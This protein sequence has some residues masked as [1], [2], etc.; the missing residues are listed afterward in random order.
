MVSVIL[1]NIDSSNGLLPD[2]T[3]LLPWADIDLL[4]TPFCGITSR[5]FFDTHWINPHF[6]IEIYTAICPR[7]NNE[8]RYV[9][10][11]YAISQPLRPTNLASGAQEP[12][13]ASD[14]VW[15][16]HGVGMFIPCCMAV[17][18]SLI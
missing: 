17:L 10:G 13:W 15:L 3:K 8:F 6:D 11:V 12:I 18:F 7:D 2:G 14:F 1:T 16:A 9:D 5:V 4:S